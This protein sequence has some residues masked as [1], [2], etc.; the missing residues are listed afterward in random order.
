MSV[1]IRL[2]GLIRRGS[3]NGSGVGT[4]ALGTVVSAIGVAEFA[5]TPDLG[6]ITIAGEWVSVVF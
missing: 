4:F 3:S 1:M 5:H 6:P 2:I